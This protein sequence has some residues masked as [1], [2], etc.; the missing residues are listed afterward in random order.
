MLVEPVVVKPETASKNA[1][2][3]D[4]PKPINGI[5]ATIE[6]KTQLKKVIMNPSLG[7]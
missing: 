1:S 2:E 7:V 3:L 5:A 4:I 6:T